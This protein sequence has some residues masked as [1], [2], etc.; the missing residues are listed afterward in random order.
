MDPRAQPSMD[1][2][3]RQ[4]QEA[5]TR[6][7]AIQERLSALQPGQ[8][9]MPAAAY[10][11]QPPPPAQYSAQPRQAE[12][13]SQ[14]P[15][16]AEY[17][18]QPPP[19]AGYYSQPPPPMYQEHPPP[20][21]HPPPSAEQQS[22][23][24]VHEAHIP[25]IL[26]TCNVH[27]DS[28]LPPG[29][30]AAASIVEQVVPGTRSTD[31]DGKKHSMVPMIIQWA[32]MLFCMA[33]YL[34]VGAAVYTQFEGWTVLEAVY[35]CMVTMSTVGYGDFSPSTDGTKVFTTFW[36]F[37]GV[38]V[39]FS[40]L[41]ACLGQLTAPVTR[42]M[43]NQLEKCFPRNY[44]D[45]DGDGDADFAYPRHIVIYYLKGMSPSLLLNV[46]LQLGSAAIFV[47]IEGWGYGDAVYHCLVTATTVG[48]G[49]ISI[50]TQEGML[51]ACFHILF[52]VVLLA[53]AMASI[54]E[55]STE[56][57]V[58][59]ERLEQLTRKFDLM[60]LDG[61]LEDAAELRLDDKPP[62][63]YRAAPVVDV[64]ETEFVLCM[65]LQMGITTKAIVRPLIKK[66]RALDADH[67]GKLGKEDLKLALAD[68]AR[69]S[70]E[71]SPPSGS[72]SR[73]KTFPSG[74]PP[75]EQTYAQRRPAPPCG[76]GGEYGYGGAYGGEYAAKEHAPPTPGAIAQ[77]FEAADVSKN[78]VIDLAE[79][80]RYAATMQQSAGMPPLPPAAEYRAP[81]ELPPSGY[82]LQ[83][84]QPPSAPQGYR[85]QPLPPVRPPPGVGYQYQSQPPPY[86]ASYGR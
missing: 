75:M 53:E 28:H 57:R 74:Q 44:I 11:S 26:G 70:A 43:R 58:A 5:E 55:L 40:Q 86:G 6:A 31:D 16:P 41:G 69:V 51:W 54:G 59:F 25:H 10:Y 48:Y 73:A 2:L 50:Q 33:L 49:D 39:V 62:A 36:V 80:Q 22:A 9:Q 83:P 52:S 65:L 19:P 46:T 60:M 79:F 72:H 24:T 82:Q 4:L 12:Y 3:Q 45:I 68:D 1:A 30:T 7:A 13:Y 76:Y 8:A 29:L 23:N 15:P 78:G 47:A 17:Y 77:A 84:V 71:A 64:A 42:A 35:F 63:G 32:C 14:P 34:V 18:S 61:L 66:F 67:S 38:L 21:I 81:P 56:R 37:I 27:H 85:R 20:H